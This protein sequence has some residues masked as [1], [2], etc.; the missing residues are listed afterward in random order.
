MKKR[1]KCYFAHSWAL[2]KT[3]IEAEIIKQLSEFYEVINPFEEEELLEDKYGHPYYEYPTKEFAKD[4]VEADIKKMEQADVLVAYVERRRQVG[5]I[6]EIFYFSQI[7]KKPVIVIC[8]SPS[9]F[10]YG[11]K[12]ITHITTFNKFFR[13]GAPELQ[14]KL[15]Q[16]EKRVRTEGGNEND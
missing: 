10:F 2:R 8:E 4:I 12:G 13:G 11:V 14:R 1:S 6:F 7:L 9:P 5:T 15:N 3:K 16:Y